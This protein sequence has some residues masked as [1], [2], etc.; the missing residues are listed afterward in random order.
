MRRITK[1]L[2]RRNGWSVWEAAVR[3][4]ENLAASHF[5]QARKAGQ[6]WLRSLRRTRA[7]LSGPAEPIRVQSLL[8]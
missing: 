5:P 6:C 7:C 4:A 3:D 2:I 1:N 8:P